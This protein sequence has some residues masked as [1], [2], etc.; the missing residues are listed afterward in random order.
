MVPVMVMRKIEKITVVQMGRRND[1]EVA[2]ALYLSGRLNRIIS[3][4]IISGW[5]Y[6]TVAL[7]R[8]IFHD[9]S[10]LEKLSLRRP[11]FARPILS[12]FNLF[13]KICQKEKRF[14]I[15]YYS[16]LQSIPNCLPVGRIYCLSECAG[17][18][19][20]FPSCTIILEV[21]LCQK[22]DLEIL[23]NQKTCEL[24]NAMKDEISL[25]EK[26][27]EIEAQSISEADY[28]VFPSE[29]V[30]LQ[31]KSRYR[32]GS[33]PCRVVNYWCPKLFRPKVIFP[34]KLSSNQTIQVIFVG[35]LT[36]IKGFDVFLDVA[37]RCENL[38]LRFH[39]VG[40]G[41]LQT[42]ALLNPR[43]NM[44]FHGHVEKGSLDRLYR[45]SHV[46]LFPTLNEGS[47][48]VSYEALSYGIP[49]ITTDGCGSIVENGVHGMVDKDLSVEKIIA[50]LME[51]V[52][53]PSLVNHLSQ[54]C[55]K[56]ARD[57]GLDNYHRNILLAIESFE[58]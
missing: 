18:K 44:I 6:A 54:N 50:K 56:H 26:L 32:L 49:I 43:P 5:T 52:A 22:R 15:Q 38:N 9:I 25:K 40:S 57:H 31:I 2:N 55:L 27:C 1:Y 29:Y 14:D 13:E 35:R 23:L 30:Y 36:V 11:T 47:A 7:L 39:V 34:K 19:A 24:N 17:L 20:R 12:V 46:F 16:F 42:Q 21:V 58:I 48:L 4:L 41:P 33:R 3:D 51:F 53:D 8:R 45:E 37:K 10:F 28:F